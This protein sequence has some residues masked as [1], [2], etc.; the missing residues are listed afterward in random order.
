MYPPSG[1][2][3]C[4]DTDTP[5]PRCPSGIPSIHLRRSALRRQ[6]ALRRRALL[7]PQKLP[8][9]EASSSYL[10]PHPRQTHRRAFHNDPLIC[11]IYPDEEER[12]MY[13]PFLW[14]YLLRDGIRY[15]EVY[16]PSDKI[17]GTAK[18]LPPGKVHMNIWRSLRSGALKMGVM[19]SKQKDKRVL[20]GR[21][22][23]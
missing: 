19:T 9:S 10:P 7:L 5:W 15:G 18:W 2:I 1:S 12:R 23:F 6:T 4:T 11:L 22:P 13:S 20:S 17:E 3:G 21:I 14:E 8:L 16:S